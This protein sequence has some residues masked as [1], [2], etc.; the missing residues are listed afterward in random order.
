MPCS[1]CDKQF[2]YGAIV[3]GSDLAH[4]AITPSL[5]AS[6]EEIWLKGQDIDDTPLN[7]A[8]AIAIFSDFAPK[9]VID[10]IISQEKVSYNV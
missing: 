1:Q 3:S 10:I 2:G 7:Q 4:V 9:D 5:M 8:R 6:C